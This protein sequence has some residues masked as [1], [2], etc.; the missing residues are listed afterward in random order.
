MKQ[1]E[2]Y[3]AHQ[4]HRKKKEAKIVSGRKC[5]PSSTLDLG[6]SRM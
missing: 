3:R 6:L 1:K 5:P 2:D 4:G